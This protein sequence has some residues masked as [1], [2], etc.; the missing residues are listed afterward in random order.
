[1][2]FSLCGLAVPLVIS[3]LV[4]TGCNK[5]KDLSNKT[6][7]TVACVRTN[8]TSGSDQLGTEIVLTRKEDGERKSQF[9]L[10]PATVTFS[11]LEPGTYE[12]EGQNTNSA[13]AESI[14][15]Q[16]DAQEVVSLIYN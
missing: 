6:A 15:L 14:Q 12:I 2:K 4:A 11:N 7:I 5:S 10:V 3:L 8:T 1:M 13:T 9:T 16:K